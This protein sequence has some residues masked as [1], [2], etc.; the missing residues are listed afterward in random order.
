MTPAHLHQIRAALTDALTDAM[1]RAQRRCIENAS[2]PRHLLAASMYLASEGYPAF[3]TQ[4][5]RYFGWGMRVCRQY[6]AGLSS[7][8]HAQ[9]VAAGKR[10]AEGLL[11]RFEVAA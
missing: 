8:V 2:M 7:E 5:E 3:P 9:E 4:A 10:A 6:L 1:I 11:V